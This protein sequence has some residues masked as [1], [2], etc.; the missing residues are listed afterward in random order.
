[1]NTITDAEQ[2]RKEV[3]LSVLRQ[4]VDRLTRTT[5]ALEA[6]MREQ[7]NASSPQAS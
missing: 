5:Q 7:T 2:L 1:M 4:I 3:S 6:L